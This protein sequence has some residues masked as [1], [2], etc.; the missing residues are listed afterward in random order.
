LNLV[1]SLERKRDAGSWTESLIVREGTPEYGSDRAITHD[2]HLFET[3]L[4]PI[5][6]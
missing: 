4:A 1:E 6:E 5:T 2:L 3:N